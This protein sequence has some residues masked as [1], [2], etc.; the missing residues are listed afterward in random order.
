MIFEVF[1]GNLREDCC[2]WMATSHTFLY[3]SNRGIIDPI[4]RTAVA[5]AVSV[6]VFS[7]EARRLSLAQEIVSV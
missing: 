1:V 7:R 3:V 4:V 5:V 2:V 6:K